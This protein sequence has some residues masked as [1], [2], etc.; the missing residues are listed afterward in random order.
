MALSIFMFSN[1]MPRLK[2][3][4]IIDFFPIDP[5]EYADNYYNLKL[6]FENILNVRIQST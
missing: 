3:I 5:L 2:L 1:P 6:A 4:F